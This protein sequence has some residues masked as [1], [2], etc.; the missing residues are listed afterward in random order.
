[1]LSEE[2]TLSEFEEMIVSTAQKIERSIEDCLAAAA[3]TPRQISRVILTGG[4]SQTPL[5]N[6]TVIKIFG[7]EKILR[8][9]YFSSV[10]TGLG[11]VASRFG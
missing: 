3:V 4:T 9:D 1:D 10:A 5:L 11:H 2:I 7:E 6:R 8:P